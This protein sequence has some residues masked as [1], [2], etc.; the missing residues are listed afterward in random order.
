MARGFNL[1][2][3]ISDVTNAPTSS[4][5]ISEFISYEKHQSE[6]QNS[7]QNMVER[8]R[9]AEYIFS[10]TCIWCMVYLYLLYPDVE[11]SWKTKFI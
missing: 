4:V 11:R 6:L 9:Y 7:N 8:K 2:G 10:F 3:L 5:S 1:G